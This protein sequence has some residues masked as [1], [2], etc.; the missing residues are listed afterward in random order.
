MR[1][2]VVGATGR[3]GVP[4][5]RDALARGHEVTA[6][7]RSPAKRSLLPDDIDVVEGDAT[8]RAA[9]DRLVAGTDAVV[10]LVA[11]ERGGPSDLRRRIVPGLLEA[12]RSHGVDRL[13]FLTGA[14]VRV[15]EDDP[16][17][18][19]RVIVW[20]MRRL[21]ADVLADG[22]QATAAVAASDVDWTIVRAPR[23]TDDE[24]RGG[25][26]AFAGVGQG[27]S[28]RIAR[29]D[30]AAWMLDELERPAWVGRHP[31]VTR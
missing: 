19:D 9:L 22:E 27:S 18:L 25:A 20:V 23:L 14:G 6:L 5:V 28:T 30:L 11:T 24:P 8:D 31:V 12:M 10:D 15:E 16:G 29:A 13:V 17:V 7:V 1:I 21:A 3:T 2:A 26:R 4:L